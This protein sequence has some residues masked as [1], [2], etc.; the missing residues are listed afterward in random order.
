MKILRTFI[1]IYPTGRACVF[2]QSIFLREAH[3]N[4]FI[5]EEILRILIAILRDNE[6][7]ASHFI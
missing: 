1:K 4:T 5:F 3:G 7:N 6:Q 2:K